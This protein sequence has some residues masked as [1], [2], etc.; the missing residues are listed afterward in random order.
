MG[1]ESFERSLFCLRTKIGRR[2][3]RR[4]YGD[5]APAA[6]MRQRQMRITMYCVALLLDIVKR[7]ESHLFCLKKSSFKGW[8]VFVVVELE[9]FRAVGSWAR[10][11]RCRMLGVGCML[12]FVAKE[13][14]VVVGESVA[15]K[16][17]TTCR[18]SSPEFCRLMSAK[19]F[20]NV[21]VGERR[22]RH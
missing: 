9:L 6:T 5:I 11:C 8:I 10:K 3:N 18:S 16:G 13:A 14:S 1:R 22:S 12:V 4:Q 20:S 19:G 21:T 2:R 15:N 17:K 7:N